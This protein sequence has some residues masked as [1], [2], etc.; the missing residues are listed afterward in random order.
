MKV[1]VASQGTYLTSNVDPRFGIARFFIVVN[2]ETGRFA[3]HDNTQHLGVAQGAGIQTAQKVVSLNVHA[4]IAG[5]VGPKAFTTLQAGNVKTYIGA[6]GLVSRTVEQFK[7][8]LL[9]CAS[10][11]NVKGHWL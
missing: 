6:T 4:A 2:T 11:P 3:T 10:K 9:K 8:G 5:N 1:A 7:A